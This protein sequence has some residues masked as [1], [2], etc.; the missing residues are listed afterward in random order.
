MIAGGAVIRQGINKGGDASGGKD[1]AEGFCQQ[2]SKNGRGVVA[3]ADIAQRIEGV[4]GA[5]STGSAVAETQVR[6]RGRVDQAGM[7]GDGT[8]NGDAKFPGGGVGDIERLAD[9]FD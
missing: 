3:G 2:V 6:E 7:D 4:V 9:L 1:V 5:L 8:G